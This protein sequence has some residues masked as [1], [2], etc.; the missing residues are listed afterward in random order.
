MFSSIRWSLIINRKCFR[1]K[2][3]KM[4]REIKSVW[5]MVN[6][7]QRLKT[8][9]NGVRWKQREILISNLSAKEK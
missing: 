1:K 2:A 8:N 6:V 9:D 7:F 5:H 3:R 4:E